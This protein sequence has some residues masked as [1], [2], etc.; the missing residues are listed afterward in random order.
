MSGFVVVAVAVTAGAL[1]F[2][3][4]RWYF[5]PE[6]KAKRALREARTV[7]IERASEGRV[8][9]VCGR[10]RYAGEPLRAPLSGRP[11][12]AW[13]VEVDEYRRSGKSGHW[14]NII[15]EMDGGPLEVE[16]D[17]GR[18]RVD[19]LGA[20]LVILRDAHFTS[21]TFNDAGPA[22]EAYLARH[23]HDSTGFLGLNR[24][25]R[26]KEG[27]LEE[28]EEV[29]VLGLARWEHD[30]SVDARGARGYR[31]LPRRLVVDATAEGKLLVS[32]DPSVTG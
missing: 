26:Y 5:G 20:Q 7:P 10:L 27:V 21:G 12:A 28:G 25:L 18:A 30:P 9:K 8:V 24:G 13:R 6:Q 16:D 2:T 4:L 17:T 23:G 14:S 31:E 1:V 22:L 3:G 29:A 19:A 15:T 32:D 11:C